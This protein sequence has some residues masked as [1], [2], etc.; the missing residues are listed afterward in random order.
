MYSLPA[1]NNQSSK[2]EVLDQLVNKFTPYAQNLLNSGGDFSYM[3]MYADNFRDPLLNQ[4][5]F[6]EYDVYSILNE[7]C[8]IS[9]RNQVKK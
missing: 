1:I 2:Q 8:D 7:A 6:T 5:N 3:N 4:T 9:W